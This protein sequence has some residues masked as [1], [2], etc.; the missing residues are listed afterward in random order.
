[1]SNFR[2][3]L[4]FLL[5]SAVVGLAAAFVI[6]FLYPDLLPAG[7]PMRGSD[8]QPDSYAGAVAA[9]APA[10]ANLVGRPTAP[11]GFAES[12][13]TSSLGSAV[14]MNSAGYVITNHHVIAGMQDLQV[15][16]V[17]GRMAPANLVGTDPDTDIALLKVELDGLPEIR[18]GRSDQLR[19]GDVVLAIGNPFSIGQT[20]TQGIISGTGRGQLGLSQFENFIQT[21]AAINVGNSGGALVSARGELV[22]INTAFFSRRLDSEGIGF[23]IPINLVRGVMEDLLEH[24]RVIR[25]WL[26]VGTQTLTPDQARA[27]GLRDAYGIILTTVQPDSP[28]DRAGLRA[29]DVITHVNDEPVVVWQDALRS[30]AAMKPG[31][32]VILGG[33]RLGR[34]FRVEAEV[35][36][37]PSRP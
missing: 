33:S 10:V 27:L 19:V 6:V 26:G 36:E 1:M 22:G 17:D 4:N 25:G 23:A 15:V 28:A 5:Q 20:V 30:I 35:T 32:K 7:H 34:P 3:T 13:A 11:A 18:V 14:V 2:Q 21:D 24:G 31:T 8:A 16:L 29:N 37:R 12:Q 9:T